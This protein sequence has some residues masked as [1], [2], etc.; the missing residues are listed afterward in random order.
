MSNEFKQDKGQFFTPENLVDFIIEVLEIPQFA[1]KKLSAGYDQEELLPYI[2]DPSC[3]SGTFLIKAMNAISSFWLRVKDEVDIP[4]HIKYI[5][6]TEL[7]PEYEGE[8]SKNWIN[9][10]SE[11]F[12]YG[13]EPNTELATAAKVNMIMQGDGSSNIFIN[14]GLADFEEYNNAVTTR[15]GKGGEVLNKKKKIRFNGKNYFVN[16][17]FDFIIT[18][19][20]FS[21]TYGNDK[22]QLRQYEERFLFPKESE[23]LFIERWYQLLKEGGK[24]G[25]ILPDSI[26]DTNSNDY[27]R[28]FLLKYFHIKAVVSVDEIAFKPYTSTKVSIL[29]AEKRQ[30]KKLKISRRNGRMHLKNI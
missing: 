2:I 29:F 14:S 16:E 15:P 20:P 27:I 25:A 9:K 28:L 1:I 6:K 18:N 21:L 23:I 3:G 13:I 5:V 11:K 12:I 7:F 30:R 22:E 10:W 24:I 8:E 26:F 17:K 19:P 4:D